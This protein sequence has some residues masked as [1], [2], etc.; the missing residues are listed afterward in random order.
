MSARLFA[1][2]PGIARSACDEQRS[3]PRFI[4]EKA[5]LKIFTGLVSAAFILAMPALAED[6]KRRELGP[7]VHGQGTLDIAIEGKKIDM[8]RSVMTHKARRLLPSRSRCAAMPKRK[9]ASRR[10][11]PL[12]R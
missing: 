6:A 7:H 9:F 4:L 8:E 2:R 1:S 12:A 5:M 10:G 3:K 11:R